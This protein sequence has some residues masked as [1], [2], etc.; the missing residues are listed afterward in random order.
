MAVTGSAACPPYSSSIVSPVSPTCAHFFQLSRENSPA[1]SRRTRS[2]LSWFREKDATASRKRS[3]SSV[4]SKSTQEPPESVLVTRPVMA[5]T[6]SKFS[7]VSSSMSIS[8]P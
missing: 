2:S 5:G 8:T 6:D 7:R 4:R 1:W 3:C